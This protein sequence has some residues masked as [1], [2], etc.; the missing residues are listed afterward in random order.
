MTM[1]RLSSR[2]AELFP[3]LEPAPGAVDV[4]TRV[5]AA[6]WDE[7]VHRHQDASGY[8]VWAWGEVFARAFGHRTEYL[9]ARRGGRIV[10]VLPLVEMRSRWFGRFMVSLPFVN[11]GGILADDRMA[12]DA[13]Y[14]YAGHL[15]EARALSHVELRHLAHQL[16][17]VPSK[18]HKVAMRLA[19]APD[20]DT[21]WGAL[22]RKVRNQVRKAEKSG[23]CCETGGRELLGDFYPVFA[24]NMR[25]LGTPV[26][27]RKFFETIVDTFPDRTTF[28]VVRAGRQAVAAGIGLRHRA[29][30]EIPWASSLRVYRPSSPNN[31]LYW[32]AIAHA[33]DTGVSVFDFG[34]STPNEGTYHFKQQWGAEPIPLCWEYWLG[35]G[36][37]MPDQ[38]PKNPKFSLAIALW[39]RLPLAVAN[40]I[41]PSIVRSIP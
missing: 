11:Y 27:A 40:T 18:H 30:L 28:F 37:A 1:P 24:S 19:L 31:L 5:S 29:T 41:G 3:R 25:D 6:E 23:L 26:Y 15:A 32:T 4:S 22:D 39:K 12:A 2:A 38:S 36:T 20:V 14:Q 8:H 16:P 33:I 13:L 21:M 17:G 35:R 34:R 9:A 7:Y 10:G